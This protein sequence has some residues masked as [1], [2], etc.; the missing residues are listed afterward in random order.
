[1]LEWAIGNRLMIQ[2]IRR[3]C[4][5][6]HPTTLAE[7]PCKSQTHP[8]LPI[9]AKVVVLRFLHPHPLKIAQL[10]HLEKQHNQHHRQKDSA[11]P[12]HLQIQT[13]LKRKRNLANLA[14]P[15][16][17]KTQTRQSRNARNAKWRRTGPPP[18]QSKPNL[19]QDYISKRSVTSLAHNNQP[20]SRSRLLCR[21]LSIRRPHRPLHTPSS[22]PHSTSICP[23]SM[24]FLQT[25]QR[26][27]Q[28]LLP[29]VSPSIPSAARRL[30]MPVR[31]TPC[32]Q[33]PHNHIT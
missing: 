8:R 9:P 7:A 25:R 28:G 10:L 4:Q 16:N 23:N 18:P 2:T 11:S 22:L 32:L 19:S 30:K 17:Q 6:P 27:H 29:L 13:R 21:L 14:N 33:S 20:R 15:K 24:P 12:K 1:M 5:R 26:Q 31:K 3:P